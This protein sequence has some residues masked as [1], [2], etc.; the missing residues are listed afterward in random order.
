[1]RIERNRHVRRNHFVALDGL[2][3][4]VISAS[5]IESQARFEIP[6]KGCVMCLAEGLGPPIR[7][8]GQAFV[9]GKKVESAERFKAELGAISSRLRFYAPVE[10]PRMQIV[11]LRHNDMIEKTYSLDRLD[12]SASLAYF[13]ASAN[14][15]WQSGNGPRS[16]CS[17]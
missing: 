6:R 13:H 5:E 1:M 17:N 4:F 3:R 2:A 14:F 9:R 11:E 8:P 15:S 7:S 12:L 10:V 16:S